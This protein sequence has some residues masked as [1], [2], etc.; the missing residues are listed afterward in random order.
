MRTIEQRLVALAQK[1][2]ARRLLQESPVDGLSASLFEFDTWCA[3]NPAEWHSLIC[4]MGGDT[5]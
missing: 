4:S 5:T 3:R 1:V 2:E